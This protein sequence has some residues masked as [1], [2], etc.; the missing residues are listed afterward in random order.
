MATLTLVSMLGCGELN[1]E[2]QAAMDRRCPGR[3]SVTHSALRNTAECLHDIHSKWSLPILTSAQKNTLKAGGCPTCGGPVYGGKD[4][5]LRHEPNWAADVRRAV[6]IRLSGSTVVQHAP[7]SGRSGPTTASTQGACSRSSLTSIGGRVGWTG[8]CGP[9]EAYRSSLDEHSVPDIFLSL[10]AEAPLMRDPKTVIVPEPPKPDSRRRSG[11]HSREPVR[12]MDW[13]FTVAALPEGEDVRL[14]SQ[15]RLER[16][17]RALSLPPG[18][19]VR[20]WDLHHRA[21]RLMI[22]ACPA[23]EHCGK[24]VSGDRDA[25]EYGGVVCLRRPLHKGECISLACDAHA[26]DSADESVPGPEVV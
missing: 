19:R 13:R 2:T 7:R 22:Y 26:A 6:P 21:H 15:E 18:W 14:I 11:E 10:T 25:A 24:V 17:V 4:A 12:P 16:W 23:P 8:Q 5:K 3:T 1:L 9:I 20:H